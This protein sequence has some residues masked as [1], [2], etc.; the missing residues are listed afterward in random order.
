MTLP[1]HAEIYRNNLEAK[2]NTRQKRYASDGYFCKEETLLTVT[3][4]VIRPE[5]LPA[6]PKKPVRVSGQPAPRPNSTPDCQGEQ[7]E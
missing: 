2:E 4:S 5:R 7:A 3:V 6:V 1:F